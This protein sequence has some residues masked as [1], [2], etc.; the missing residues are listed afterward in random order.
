TPTQGLIQL[1]AANNIDVP[2]ETYSVLHK[3]GTSTTEVTEGVLTTFQANGYPYQVYKIESAI[4]I[5]TFTPSHYDATTCGLDMDLHYA[6][7]ETYTKYDNYGNLLE[8]NTRGN[9]N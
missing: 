1:I 8:K 2:V 5:A 4:P 9:K 7:Q 3:Y 6:L